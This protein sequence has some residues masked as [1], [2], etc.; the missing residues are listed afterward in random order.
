[1]RTLNRGKPGHTDEPR[2]VTE[3]QV[4]EGYLGK[5]GLV[6]ETSRVNSL[7]ATFRATK[8]L[9]LKALRRTRR[10]LSLGLGLAG[11][12]RQ[13][14]G[15]V[16]SPSRR[17][18]AVRMFQDVILPADL[19]QQVLRGGRGPFVPGPRSSIPSNL[20]PCAVGNLPGQPGRRAPRARP[21]LSR[22]PSPSSREVQAGRCPSPATKRRVYEAWLVV[23]WPSTTWACPPEPL[24]E[25]A[26]PSARPRDARGQVL[27]LSVATRNAKGN[28]APFRH[29]LLYGPPGTGKTMVAKRL[30]SAARLPHNPRKKMSCF[31]REDVA[32][33]RCLAFFGGSP[34]STH[35]PPPSRFVSIDEAMRH[36]ATQ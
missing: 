27:T 34:V 19:K 14:Q 5:P 10:S 16:A 9:A 3:Q 13:P 21:V 23:S 8:S 6:R 33:R 25:G 1:M 26:D 22:L 18:E 32:G 28:G 30:V 12:W 2:T 7:G 17:E 31:H 20:A 15:G 11:T 24:L 4:V 35:P 36:P 29:L